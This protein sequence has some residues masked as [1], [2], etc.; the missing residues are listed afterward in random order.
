MIGVA[1]GVGE[2]T[3]LRKVVG[4]MLF[5]L[6][7]LLGDRPPRLPGHLAVGVAGNLKNALM[8]F[9]IASLLC[10]ASHRSRSDGRFVLHAPCAMLRVRLVRSASLALLPSPSLLSV[11]GQLIALPVWLAL[12][13]A[14]AFG[15]SLAFPVRLYCAPLALAFMLTRTRGPFAGTGV[16]VP[17]FLDRLAC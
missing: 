13:F 2:D 16:T 5:C 6:A 14:L 3:R 15:P 12:R 10:S 8:A 11:C 4:G 1:N 7:K 17:F 9:V